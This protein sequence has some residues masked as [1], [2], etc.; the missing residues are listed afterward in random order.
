MHVKK[1]VY[2]RRPEF[3]LVTAVNRYRSPVYNPDGVTLIVAHGLAFHKEHLEP[4]LRHLFALEAAGEGYVREA[5]VFDGPHHGEAA[6]NNTDCVDKKRPVLEYAK[7]IR[8]F[9]LNG[10][11][12]FENHRLIALGHSLGTTTLVTSWTLLGTE[13]PLPYLAFICCEPWLFHPKANL[14]AFD[15]ARLMYAKNVGARKNWWASRDAALAYFKA[16]SPWNLWDSDVLDLYVKY[17]LRPTVPKDGITKEG[18][19]TLSCPREHEESLYY[20]TENIPAFEQLGPMCQSMDV[21][22][23]LGGVDT[24]STLP[25]ATK[26]MLASAEEGR[27]MVSVREV[28]GG[29]H[30]IPAE[31]PRSFAEVLY[32]VMKILPPARTATSGTK[33]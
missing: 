14:K 27:P 17:G 4:T 1:F 32:V 12:S 28:P 18:G 9:I 19:V 11:I 25:N 10:P 5:Y 16:R 7:S 22:L 26:R 24:A 20:S 23:L 2:D 29:E 8:H 15:R 6:L 3:P 21:H 31:N 13:K 30:L 33:L